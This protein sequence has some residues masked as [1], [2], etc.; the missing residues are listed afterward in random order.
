MNQPYITQLKW[1]PTNPVWNDLL[2]VEDLYLKGRQMLVGKGY[3]TNFWQD[4][5]CRNID[6]KEKFPNLFD[7]SNE[8]IAT[9]TVTEIEQKGGG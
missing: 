9:V 1:K 2:E 5:W 6:F 4:T 8:K 7:I 3:L